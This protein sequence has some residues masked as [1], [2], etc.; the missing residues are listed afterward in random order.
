LKETAKSSSLPYIISDIVVNES[1]LIKH[2]EVMEAHYS[3]LM[4]PALQESRNLNALAIA[5]TVFLGPKY[6]T[7]PIQSFIHVIIKRDA[8]LKLYINNFI[9]VITKQSID[10]QTFILS[11]LRNFLKKVVGKIFIQTFTNRFTRQSIQLLPAY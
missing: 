9:K 7:P 3:E 5:I 10:V 2:Y 6:T 1:Y 8:L 4:L 11:K